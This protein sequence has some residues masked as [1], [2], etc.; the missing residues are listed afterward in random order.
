M[1]VHTFW[2]FLDYKK[3]L[4]NQENKYNK[5]FTRNACFLFL[6][7]VPVFFNHKNGDNYFIF[8]TVC[9]AF[10]SLDN[11]D[12]LHTYW[13]IVFYWSIISVPENLPSFFALCRGES[14]CSLIHSIDRYTVVF[15]WIGSLE[16]K[17]KYLS[18][19]STAFSP[20]QW[21]IHRGDYCTCKKKW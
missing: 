17:W 10:W 11:Q 2:H 21:K 8:Q 16:C 20:R 15:L 14:L 9:K 4:K 1:C 7:S 12:M 6:Y 3:E 18:M 13:L 5:V 19:K